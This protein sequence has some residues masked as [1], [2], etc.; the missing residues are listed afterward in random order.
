MK[1]HQVPMS[2]T[3]GEEAS[4]VDGDRADGERRG[5]LHDGHAALR[6]NRADIRVRRRRGRQN[7]RQGADLTIVTVQRSAK[8]CAPGLVNFIPA[9]GYHFCLNLTA[10]FMQPGAST[11]ADLCNCNVANL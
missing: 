3:Q 7:E 6:R 2:V 1:T 5:E 4:D 11:L 9:V 8:V 10:G